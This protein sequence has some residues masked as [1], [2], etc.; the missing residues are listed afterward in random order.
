[1]IRSN[2][3]LLARGLLTFHKNID[4]LIAL[5]KII[6]YRRREEVVSNLQ[7]YLTQ[8]TSTRLPIPLVGFANLAHMGAYHYMPSCFIK[9][10]FKFK[11][12]NRARAPK[13]STPVL[14][15]VQGDKRI[16]R[17]TITEQ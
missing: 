3:S 9:L 16:P 2:H 10:S 12:K 15:A 6:L 17:P 8:S 13:V 1:M 4:P 7:A 14:L 11:K 5:K